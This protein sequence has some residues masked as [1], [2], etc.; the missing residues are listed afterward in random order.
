MATSDKPKPTGKPTPNPAANPAATP[1]A[2]LRDPKAGERGKVDLPAEIFGQPINR[3]VMW[4]AVD[5][6]LTNQRQGTASVKTRAA[7][8]GGGIKPWRQKGTGRAR[9][10]TIR[11]PIWVGGG[12]A[13]GP[14]P[15]DHRKQLPKKV[16]QLAF[17][18]ALSVRAKDGKVFVVTDV[19]VEQGKTRELF[20]LLTSMGLA[21]KPCLLVID[22]N[23]PKV[24]RAGRNIP[25]LRTTSAAQANTYDVL[26]AENIVVTQAAVTALKEGRAR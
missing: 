12:R 20:G 24:L 4:L 14:K 6:H 7:V 15:H 18:S 5:V 22:G 13:F 25:W 11:S 19:G 26:R 9:S 16:R 17:A 23:D 8:S 21:N 2:Q 10:G 3:H 1:S